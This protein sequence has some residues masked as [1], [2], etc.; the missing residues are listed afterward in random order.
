MTALKICYYI[1]D[2]EGVGLT[3]HTTNVEHSL[4]TATLSL[5]DTLKNL[6]KADNVGVFP[7]LRG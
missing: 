4:Q 7:L 1:S 2:F 5:S 3:P 6:H